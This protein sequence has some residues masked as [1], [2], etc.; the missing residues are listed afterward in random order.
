MSYLA[1]LSLI[2]ISTLLITTRAANFRVRNNCRY[3]VWAAASNPG[4]GRRLN[5]NEEWSFDT[6]PGTARARIW[7][8]TNCNFGAS[9]QGSCETGDCGSLVCPTGRYGKAPNTLAEYALNQNSPGYYTNLDFFDIS[10]VDGFNIPMEFGPVANSGGKCEARRCTS[11][12]NGQCP[13]PLRVP[14]GCN[15]PCTTFREERY[16]CNQGPCGPTDYSR[17]FKDR[18]PTSY[19]YPQDDATSLFTCPGGTNYKVVFCP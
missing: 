3:V 17:F 19:S 15:N 4:G 8:R 9:G 13:G 7:G 6:A 14:G 5:T 12:I 10:L 16:C 1:T 2:I 18:C 11:D